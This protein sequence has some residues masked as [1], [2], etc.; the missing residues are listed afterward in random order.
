MTV[1]V[2]SALERDRI[3]ELDAAEIERVAIEL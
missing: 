1:S 2:L 3:L